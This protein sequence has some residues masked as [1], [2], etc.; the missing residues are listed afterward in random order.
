LLLH[1]S[2]QT[3]TNLWSYFI[4]GSIITILMLLSSLNSSINPYIYLI[5]NKNLIK[6]VKDF[7][8]HRNVSYDDDNPI[9]NI[10]GVYCFHDTKISSSQTDDTSISFRHCSYYWKSG[11]SLTLNS[12]HSRGSPI[13]LRS[14]QFRK[15]LSNSRVLS[16][17]RSMAFI[18]DCRTEELN[19]PTHHFWYYI[20][21]MYLFHFGFS[22]SSV[23]FHK[24]YSIYLNSDSYKS[25]RKIYFFKVIKIAY[26][27]LYYYL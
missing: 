15:P 14:A 9:A 10:N 22:L 24:S 23:I 8:F 5:F 12:S 7:F 26:Y 16:R 13:Q 18:S 27:I 19:N 21:N 25:I 17:Q 20:W 4:S 1:N 2:L 11:N 6:S 3:H